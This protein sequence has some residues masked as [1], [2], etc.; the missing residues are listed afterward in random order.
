MN[1]QKYNT[2]NKTMEKSEFQLR[3]QQRHSYLMIL[4][5]QKKKLLCS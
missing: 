3:P 2:S 5:F 1:N 4:F